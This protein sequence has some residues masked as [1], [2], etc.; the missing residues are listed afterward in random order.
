MGFIISNRSTDIL[1]THVK[2]T[3]NFEDIGR[4][5]CFR[6]I[7]SRAEVEKIAATAQMVPEIFSGLQKE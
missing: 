3:K 1:V 2:V 4:S 7:C 6:A 5:F